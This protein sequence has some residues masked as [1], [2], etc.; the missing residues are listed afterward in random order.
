V[1]WNK[2]GETVL[3]G[4]KGDLPKTHGARFQ[5]KID[6]MIRRGGPFGL[7]LGEEK[8]KSGVEWEGEA[9]RGGKNKQKLSGRQMEKLH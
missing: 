1:S 5:V 3:G 6:R 9:R 7:K 4:E 2:R 8:K